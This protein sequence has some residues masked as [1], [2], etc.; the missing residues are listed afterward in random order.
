MGEWA[1]VGHRIAAVCIRPWPPKYLTN[2][3]TLENQFQVPLS[4]DSLVCTSG[5][6]DVY[7]YISTW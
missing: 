6:K 4:T 2:C 7:Q 5:A 1:T 3:L